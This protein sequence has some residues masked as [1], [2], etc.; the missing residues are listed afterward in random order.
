MILSTQDITHFKTGENNYASYVLTW[1]VHRVSEIKNADIK[2]IFNKDEKSEQESLME[3]VRKLE[4]H[5]SLYVDGEKRVLKIRD[6]AFW[7][8]NM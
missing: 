5:Y 8:L 7:E 2:A 6:K 4:K 1:V 3:T